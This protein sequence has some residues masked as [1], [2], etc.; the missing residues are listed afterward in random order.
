M[1]APQAVLLSILPVADVGTVVRPCTLSK[2]VP[3]ILLKTTLV[4]CSITVA[5][6]AF[7]LKRVHFE[8]TLIRRVLLSK[9]KL[10]KTIANAIFP[11]TLVIV[12]IGPLVNADSIRLIV[13][14]E[15]EVDTFVGVDI[16][17]Q[18]IFLVVLPVTC[19]L[20]PRGG[21]FVDTKA[22]LLGLRVE[23]ADVSVT[24]FP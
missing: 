22:F 13:I 4:A 10:A 20:R 14:V 7:A 5:E 1:H 18:S 16:P 2:A 19:V 3:L 15:T 8:F 24:T 17:S 6:V 9:L 12:A 23:P 21:P 11:L